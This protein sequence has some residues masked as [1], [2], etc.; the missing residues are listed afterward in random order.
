MHGAPRSC[1]C[2][3]Y[4]PVRHSFNVVERMA[5]DGYVAC[6]PDAFHRYD[7]DRGPIERAEARIDPTDEEALEDMDETIA[8]LR[9]LPYVDGDRIGIA[10]FCLSGRMPLVF[11]AARD[12]ATAIAVFHGGV[13]PREFEPIYPGQAPASELIAKL[14]CP[15]LGMFGENDLLLPL[16][17]VARFRH[18]LEQGGKRYRIRVFAGAPHSWLN[19]T[20]PEAYRPRE[21]EEAWRGMLGF[22]REVFAG[23]WEAATPHQHFEPDPEIAFDF[24]L[25][26]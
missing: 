14:S 13:Y 12:S 10:G 19:S 22:F 15:V 8:H 11:A 17:N 26:H 21:A 4:G 16:E 2:E 9:S 25:Q 1:C 6:V 20:T 18:E 5:T 7:D 24:H 3:R 23:E